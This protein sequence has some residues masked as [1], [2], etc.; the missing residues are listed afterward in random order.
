MNN[1]R[2]EADLYDIIYQIAR[3]IPRGR[4]TSYGAIAA[5]IGMKSGARVVGYAMNNAQSQRPPVPAHR[6]VNRQGLLTGR[7]HF[8]TEG[9]MQ[10]RLEAEGIK[11]VD[12][13]VQNF[14]KLFWD[15]ATELTDF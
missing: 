7:H 3:K 8:G 14:D 6:V 10:R 4:V 15:P 12:D 11:V 1:N 2:K 5:A 13:T 9:E